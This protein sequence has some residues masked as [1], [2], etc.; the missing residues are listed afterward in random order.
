MQA[1]PFGATVREFRDRSGPRFVRIDVLLLAAVLGLTACSL[2]TIAAATQ[3]DVAGSPNHFVYR[4]AIYVAV[5]ICL[6]LVISR[7]DYGRLREWKAGIYTT[8]IGGILLVFV[9]GSVTRGSK[10]AIDLPFFEIQ[11]S[12]LGK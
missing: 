8:L 7:L 12:E 5:G 10:R 3:D 11:F 4:Q 6:M 1:T 9:L 2:Y